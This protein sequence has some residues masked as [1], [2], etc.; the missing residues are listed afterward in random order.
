MLHDLTIGH[1][2]PEAIEHRMAVALK[3]LDLGIVRRLLA[4]FP[5]LRAECRDGYVIVPWHG[6]GQVAQ[7]EEFALRLQ[8]ETDCLIADRRNCRVVQPDRLRG[9]ATTSAITPAR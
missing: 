9:Q 6:K 5:G 4:E 3:P 8:R 7:G 1:L 2:D